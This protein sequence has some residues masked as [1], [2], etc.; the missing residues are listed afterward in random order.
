MVRF[1]P[2]WLA[3]VG[4]AGWALLVCGCLRAG[5]PRH[6][7]LAA[8]AEPGPPRSEEARVVALGPVQV[9]LHLRQMAIVSR[10]DAH[11][12]VYHDGDLW[13]EPLDD[14]IP[15]LLATNLERLQPGRVVRFP[16]REAGAAVCRFAVEIRSFE[17]TASGEALLAAR[18]E[19]YGA[20]GS[21]RRSEEALI[22]EPGVLGL[23]DLPAALSRAL[24]DLSRRLSAAVPAAAVP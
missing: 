20:D 15:H 4:M 10:A 12:L 3:W 18:W 7:T 17:L 16:A 13:A 21:F 23:A 24:L 14:A 5:A 9:P 6:Y 19:L 2:V 8:L 22:V 11:R 1:R